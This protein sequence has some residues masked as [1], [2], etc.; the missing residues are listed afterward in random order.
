MPKNGDFSVFFEKIG[1]KQKK[2][3]A[4]TDFFRFS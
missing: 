3:L 4:G 1:R 2:T